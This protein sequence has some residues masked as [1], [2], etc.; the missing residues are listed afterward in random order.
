[1]SDLG[2]EIA[3]LHASFDAH[4]KGKKREAVEWQHSSSSLARRNRAKGLKQRFQRICPTCNITINV[5]RHLC[6]CGY[7]FIEAR[8]KAEREKEARQMES[9]KKAAN[10]RIL[11]RSLT[12]IKKHSAKLRGGGY[13][14]ATVYYKEC[15]QRTVKGILPGS[16]LSKEVEESLVS[17]FYYAHTKNKQEKAKSAQHDQLL[18]DVPQ[19]V[20]PLKKKIKVDEERKKS[21]T[22][23]LNLANAR[24]E[25]MDETKRA[26]QDLI[27]NFPKPEEET[28]VKGK[29]NQGRN[30]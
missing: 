23:S 25:D 8:R 5:G 2:K 13:H 17:W 9:G 19:Q 24:I 12:A 10:N 22:N 3:E 4:T 21:T 18:Y 1:M 16:G 20:I 11:A 28:H 15:S 26:Q 29:E 7:S 14:L 6:D 27:F 30:T